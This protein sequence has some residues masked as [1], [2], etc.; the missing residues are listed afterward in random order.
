M[1]PGLKDE[2]SERAGV[3]YTVLRR[4][5][6]S[7]PLFLPLVAVVGGVLGGWFW[8]L[9]V[10][11]LLLVAV[12]KLWRIGIAALLCVLVACLQQERQQ[13]AVE[14]LQEYLSVHD[15]VELQG[16]V[17]RKLTSGCVLSSH[18]DGAKVVV[19]GE[20]IPWQ[21]GDVVKVKAE[22]GHVQHPLVQGMFDSTRW[23]QQQGIAASL[24]LVQGEY[25]GHPFS[26]AA[27][28]GAAL[29]VRESLALRLMP[30]GTENDARRQV[31]CALVLGDKTRAEDET[32]LDF[33]KGGCLHAFAVS[34]LHVGLL[35]GIL[36]GMLRLCRV[37]VALS[38]IV[39]LLV[40]GLYVVMTG[41]AV[42]AVRAYM[43]AAVVLGGAILHKRVSLLNTWSFVAL[44]V[45]LPQP[46]QIYNA[47]FQLSFIVYAAICVGMRLSLRESPWFGPN[48]YIPYR[49]RTNAERRLSSFELGVRGVVI[50]SLWAWLVS[51]PITI[52]QFHTLNTHSFL[53]NILISPILPVVMA[54]GLAAMILGAVPFIGS[55]VTTL[56]LQSA[57][58]LITVV[59]MCGA[60]PAAYLPAQLPQPPESMML[61]STGYGES[62]CMLGNG[63][64]LIA[65]GNAPTA[66]FNIEPAVFHS[67]FTPAGILLPK[68][69][70]KR[71]EMSAVLT[72]TWPHARLLDADTLKGKT[73][74]ATKAGVFRI[75][76]APATIPRKPMDNVTPIVMWQREKDRVLYVGDAS[77]LT[78][79]SIPEEERKADILILGRNQRMPLADADTIRSIGASTIILLPSVKDLPQFSQ[80]SASVEIVRMDAAPA[81]YFCDKL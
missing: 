69:S 51:L 54:T 5:L 73:D 14:T 68:P 32:M 81:V 62:A 48:D 57:Q 16:T 28:C 42:P 61:I 60:L 3:L 41:F 38:R 46:Y 35:G 31:L 63:G 45:L 47:G 52:A 22:K 58:G 70:A 36:W 21:L 50:I 18:R 7:A 25:L 56:A 78:F 53:T 15:V 74:L 2:S 43:M 10:F 29:A 79:E 55:V 80:D 4:I 34:G 77:L 66:R 23:M 30:P 6:L 19:R 67:G 59:A 8:C 33:R 76:A 40:C 44:L 24:H 9:A 49:I 11:S 1:E 26:W 71:A 37:R 65:T 72:A 13:H 75:Y 64:L 17:V 20:Q 12:L 27:F 39:I